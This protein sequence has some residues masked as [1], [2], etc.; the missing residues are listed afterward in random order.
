MFE[1]VGK[2][3]VAVW[4]V[5]QAVYLPH[6]VP[7]E[8]VDHKKMR[9]KRKRKKNRSTRSDPQKILKMVTTEEI[10]IETACSAACFPIKVCCCMAF[11]GHL[12][13]WTTSFSSILKGQHS[14]IMH[15][16]HRTNSDLLRSECNWKIAYVDK[17]LQS[18]LTWYQQ[19]HT[20]SISQGLH[21]EDQPS[22]TLPAGLKP[23]MLL[24]SSLESLQAQLGLDLQ[25]GCLQDV[26]FFNLL[27]LWNS[28]LRVSD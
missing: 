7:L 2:N 25:S 19:N 20:K 28:S 23:G 24:P 10:C 15:T 11:A 14:I 16:G 12:T 18:F 26:I 21:V 27:T 22:P 6:K 3:H 8:W 17:F 13:L 1:A 9:K 5:I 4:L